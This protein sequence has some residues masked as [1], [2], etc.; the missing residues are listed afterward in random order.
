MA[1][2]SW[3]TNKLQS[4]TVA[5]GICNQTIIE[6][7]QEIGWQIRAAVSLT[8]HDKFKWW[9]KVIEDKNKLIVP[10]KKFFKTFEKL[11]Q[12]RNSW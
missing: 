10:I 9:L 12:K 6:S 4:E 1:Q 5:P 3:L 2:R 7:Y 11:R 8:H